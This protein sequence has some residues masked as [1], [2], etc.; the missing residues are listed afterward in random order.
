MRAWVGGWVSAPFSKEL[1]HALNLYIYRSNLY[2]EA[3]GQRGRARL[4]P[5]C[6]SPRKRELITPVYLQ[7]FNLS[8]SPSLSLPLS[9]SLVL[10][11]EQGVTLISV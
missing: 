1:C 4:C 10:T 11:V 7:T 9:L 6:T 3:G 2:R 5:L 8:L